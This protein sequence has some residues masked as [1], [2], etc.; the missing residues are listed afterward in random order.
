MDWAQQRT[1]CP[2]LLHIVAAARSVS[3]AAADAAA[4]AAAGAP[5]VVNGRVSTRVNACK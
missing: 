3:G 4:A 5:D 1:L 2:S